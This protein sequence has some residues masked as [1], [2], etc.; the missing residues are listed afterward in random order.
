M[1]LAV[2]TISAA[3]EK[4]RSLRNCKENVSDNRKK[5]LS[6]LASVCTML[7]SDSPA[8]AEMKFS[9]HARCS[10]FNMFIGKGRVREENMW[11]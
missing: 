7:D 10:F 11:T 9:E 6:W 2:G 3:A 1:E 8:R 5:V 4:T